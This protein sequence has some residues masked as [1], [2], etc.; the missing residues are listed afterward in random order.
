[1]SL[2]LNR[3]D[4]QQSKVVMHDQQTV[5]TSAPQISDMCG[6]QPCR[7]VLEFRGLSQAW[8]LMNMHAYRCRA[9]IGPFDVV[10]YLNIFKLKM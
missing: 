8:L 7:G 2:A 6:T 3:V 10:I 4:Q 1:M 9:M 5:L